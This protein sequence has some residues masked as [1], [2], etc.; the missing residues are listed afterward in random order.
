MI[1]DYRDCSESQLVFAPLGLDGFHFLP[2]A[3][4][5]GCIL[6]ASRLLRAIPFHFFCGIDIPGIHSEDWQEALAD[7]GAFW[8]ETGERPLPI[9]AFPRL[10]NRETW[11]TRPCPG[12]EKRETWGTRFF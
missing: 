7:W 2:T 5:V 9:C 6:A 3:C 1:D 12:L 11:G 8:V 10:E 4:A